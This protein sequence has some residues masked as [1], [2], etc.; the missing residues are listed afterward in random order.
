[1][2]QFTANGLVIDSLADIRNKLKAKAQLLFTDLVPSGE[3][4][5]VDDSSVLGR[6]IGVISDIYN[7]QEQALQQLQASK[8]INQATD[9]ALDDLVLLGGA[10]RKPASAGNVM[11]M[12]YGELGTTVDAGSF[13]KSN[14]TNDVFKHDSDV[15]FTNEDCYGVEV[16]LA[17]VGINTAYSLTWAVD[18]V[19]N[20]NVV[21]ECFV[22]TTDSE[23]AI[24][25]KLASTINNTT[26]DLIA[27]V[28][29]DNTVK[30]TLAN[31]N[32]TGVFSLTNLDVVRVYKPVSAVNTV[33][34]VRPNDSN[35]INNIQSAVSGWLGVTNPFPAI[36]G[37]YDETDAE[38]RTSYIASKSKAGSGAREALLGALEDLTGVTYVSVTDNVLDSPVQDIPAHGYAVTVLGGKES[39]IAQT[40]LDNAPLGIATTGDITIYPLDRNG[41]LVPISFSRPTFVPIKVNMTLTLYPNFPDNGSN[42]IKQALVDYITTFQVGVDG[43]YSRFYIPINTVGGFGVNTLHIAKVGEAFGTANIITNHNE[44]L[45]L[46]AVDV[47]FGSL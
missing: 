16:E 12:L 9:K 18:G 41:N 15:T 38:L 14:I 21:I 7:Q 34:G 27:S 32:N 17:D 20:T 6:L 10:F 31:A 45:T 24:A 1:M 40:I 33:V 11:L 13:T 39:E 43:I 28:N 23:V 22:L 46:D 2:A 19:P 29:N 5:D 26:I 37:T 42:L 44:L 3:Q 8:D 4:L 47:T 36:S 25:N 30:V 35:T